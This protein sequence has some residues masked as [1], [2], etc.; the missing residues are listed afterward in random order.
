[1]T[2]KHIVIVGYDDIMGL[3]LVGPMEAFGSAEV[4][5]SRGLAERCY[6]VTIAALQGK[7]FRSEFGLRFAAEKSLASISEA[8][9]VIVPGGSALR[10]SNAPQKLSEWLLKT[11]DSI[12]RIASICT[13][14][15]G[16]APSG[17]LDGRRVSTHWKFASDLAKRYPKLKVDPSSLYI[18]DGK[19]WTAAG[20]TAGID[21]S[22]ALIEEDFGPEVA[23]S[24]AR[25]LVVYMK[26]PGGQE[27]YSEPLQ[28]QLQSRS[29]FA[30]LLPWMVA[31]LDQDLSVDVLADKISLCPRQFSRRFAQEF[32]S[33]PASFVRRLR[34]DEARQRLSSPD[35]TVE[36]VARSVG[37]GD[38]DNFRR[39]FE[40]CFGIAPSAY[41][42][43]FTV[44]AHRKKAAVPATHATHESR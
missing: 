42:G 15:Y 23:L 9:T 33:S 24:V 2:P 37:F 35:C 19:F 38:A 16:I 1:M 44:K 4:K 17:L 28:F 31:H 20:V 8:D 40:R 34:L 41:R 25:D 14:I 18:K 12:R 39:A 32:G 36:G 7:T 29:R 5:S 27:Q 3:D 21:L 13:G 26:R 43:R 10:R 30:D 11:A 22:L 6:R